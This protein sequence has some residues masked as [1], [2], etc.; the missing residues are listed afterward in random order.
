MKYLLGNQ[1]NAALFSFIQKWDT[2]FES[3]GYV[4]GILFHL[5]MHSYDSSHMYFFFKLVNSIPSL[6]VKRSTQMLMGGCITMVLFITEIPTSNG[7]NEYL[8]DSQGRTSNL[9]YILNHSASTMLY[10][11]HN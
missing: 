3:V 2:N 4:L 8:S 1:Y 11:Y 5:L 10:I 9:S 6:V 7:T